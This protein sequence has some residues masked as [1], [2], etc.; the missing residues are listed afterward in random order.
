MNGFD[1]MLT[2]TLVAARARLVRIATELS[3]QIAVS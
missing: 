1:S 2:R 3:N